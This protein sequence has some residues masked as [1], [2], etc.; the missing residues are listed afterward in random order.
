MH[1]LLVT[2]WSLDTFHSWRGRLV[3]FS[4]DPKLGPPVVPFYPFVGEGS[5]TKIDCG[6]KTSST[7]ILAGEKIGYQLILTSHFWRT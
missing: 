4:S 2:G 7:L 5:P 1:A 3:T 6:E